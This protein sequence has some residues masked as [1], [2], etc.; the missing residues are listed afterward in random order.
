MGNSLRKVWNRCINMVIKDN[1]LSKNKDDKYEISTFDN[2]K[3]IE[4]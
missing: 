4:E 3:K 2:K 1:I